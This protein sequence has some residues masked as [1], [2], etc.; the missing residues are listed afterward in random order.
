MLHIELKYVKY[1]KIA[2]K[3]LNLIIKGKKT[4][5]KLNFKNTT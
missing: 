4:P 5:I 3:L 2:F 1:A